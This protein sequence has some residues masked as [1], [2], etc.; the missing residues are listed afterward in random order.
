[1]RILQIVKFYYPLIGGVEK[2]AQDIAEKLNNENIETDVLCC[3]TKGKESEERISGVKIYRS[4]S[5]GVFWGMPISFN[6]FKVF[7]Q[8]RNNYDIIAFHHP[9]PL[10]DLALFLFRIRAKLIIHYHSDIVRQKIL[11]IFYKPLILKTLAKADKIIV[12][13]PNLIK[14]SKYLQKF[15]E[16]CEV[17]PPGVNLEKFYKLKDERMIEEIKKKYGQFILFIGR[18]SYYKGVPYLIRAMRNIKVNL[19]IVGEGAEKERLKLEAKKNKVED[20]IFFIPHQDEKKLINL[21]YAC[22]LFVLPSIFKSEAFGLVLTEAMACGKPVIS[23]ELGT[24]TSWI[25]VDGKTGFVVSP[26]NSQSMAIAIN[27]ILNDKNLL[28]KFGK[29]SF[30]R[31]QDKFSQEKFIENIKVVYFN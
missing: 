22:E 18:I 25:N 8:I 30:L 26:K 19:L 9:F 6:F 4:S 15:Q 11:E 10:G 16:K 2:T 27:K 31:A 1:M 5:K 24:G 7:K 23:T 12:S 13:N 21:Y 28:E 17:V 20:K 29:E 3:A 14:N